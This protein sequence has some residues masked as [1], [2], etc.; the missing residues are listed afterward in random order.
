MTGRLALVGSG[1]YLPVMLEVERGLLR[2]RPATY[3]QIP[4]AAA[5]E[6]AD[7]LNRWVALG[8]EQ[9][10]RLGV[11]AVP[12]VIRNRSEA[13]DPSLAGQ[14]AG[15]GLI[16]LSGGSP[17]F[18]ASTL[19]G[20][21][22]GDAIVAAWRDGTAVAGCSAGA[23]ALTSWVPNLR[24]PGAEPVV[25]LGLVDRLRVIPHFDR[26]VGW[27]PD[28]VSRYLA[29]SPE[30]VDVIGVDEDTALVWDA[31]G[32]TVQGR[33]RVWLL[34]RD[35]RTAFAAGESLPLAPPEG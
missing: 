28:L 29:R 19:R 18:L 14:L 5:R 8:R 31:S 6:G 3:A 2:D 16:Y 12:L 34:R 21:L 25:G 22:V 7:S 30:G 33:Q 13:D 15:A 10:T 1:E 9:A 23:M 4:T 35:G 27:M 11:S 20:T 26:F 17:T 24:R 32:W